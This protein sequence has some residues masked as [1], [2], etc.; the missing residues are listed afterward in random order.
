MVDL[1]NS[2]SLENQYSAVGLGL[3]LAAVSYIL[4][5]F[6]GNLT[7]NKSLLFGIFLII[8]TFNAAIAETT[9]ET[10]NGS[11]TVRELSEEFRVEILV[12]E[13]PLYY[14]DDA[15]YGFVAKT[16]NV[17]ESVGVAII[18]FSSGGSGCPAIYR[19]VDLTFGS[20]I[21]SQQFGSCS[22]T[23]IFQIVEGKIQIDFPAF[24][25]VPAERWVYSD[26]KL[27]QVR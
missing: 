13:R 23:P 17:Y 16:Y 9:I 19:I 24:G 7:M 21:L 3:N 27:K 15:R 14:Q 6:D 20:P 1:T 5:H 12:D 18:G 25:E 4:T 22:D 8:S 10:L 11:L 2:L 26:S